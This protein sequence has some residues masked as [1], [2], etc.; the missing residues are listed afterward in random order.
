MVFT[1]SLILY[2]F[3]RKNLLEFL[4]IYPGYLVE[5]GLAG[6]VDTLYQLNYGLNSINDP[7]NIS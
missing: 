3:S 6:F 4:K 2:G 1:C 5:I 7:F